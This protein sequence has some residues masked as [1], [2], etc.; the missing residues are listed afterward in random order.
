M[1]WLDP[2]DEPAV[3]AWCELEILSAGLFASLTADGVITP[4]GEPRKALSEYRMLR[5]A[6]LAYERELGMTPSARMNLRVGDSR[7]RT[8]DVAAELAEGRRL[9]LA[10]EGRIEG[11][12]P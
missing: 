6:Q 11:A 9:R 1:P 4:K 3:R 8:F 7:A 12:Q 10:A 5:Q 2:A